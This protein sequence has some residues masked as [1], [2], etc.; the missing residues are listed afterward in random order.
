MDEQQ[1]SIDATQDV[2]IASKYIKK[3]PVVIVNMTAITLALILCIA[4]GLLCVELSDGS[5]PQA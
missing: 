4:S 5:A 3:R 2:S 1:E